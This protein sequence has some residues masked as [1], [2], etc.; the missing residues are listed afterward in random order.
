[1]VVVSNMF[2][3]FFEISPLLGDWKVATQLFFWS[4]LTGA[5]VSNGWRKYHQL[6]NGWFRFR[7]SSFTFVEM[8]P[9]SRGGI[10]SL[11]GGK[12]GEGFQDV[13]C[14]SWGRSLVFE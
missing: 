10:P 8:V 6:E 1:M 7:F 9:F 12:D 11:S 13:C 4:N 14:L 5:Y 2:F 3:F